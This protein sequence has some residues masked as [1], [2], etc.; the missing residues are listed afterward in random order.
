M[1]QLTIRVKLK[2]VFDVRLK[3]NVKLVHQ[4][5]I[6]IQTM[7]VLRVMKPKL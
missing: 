5:T 6:L 3:Q 2:I 4:T 1:L 7:N